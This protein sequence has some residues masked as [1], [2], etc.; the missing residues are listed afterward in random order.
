MAHAASNSITAH[1]TAGRAQFLHNQKATTA[2]IQRKPE[3]SEPAAGN[4]SNATTGGAQQ[5][6][7][8]QA[9]AYSLLAPSWQNSAG[10]SKQHEKMEREVRQEDYTRQPLISRLQPSLTRA[11]QH[12]QG[13]AAQLA[14]CASLPGSLLA[15]QQQDHDFKQKYHTPALTLHQRRKHR[16]HQVACWLA[17]LTW[18][19]AWLLQVARAAASCAPLLISGEQG[20]DLLGLA[21]AVHALGAKQQV[22]EQPKAC[23]GHQAA[24]EWALL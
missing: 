6:E 11:Q 1:T 4:A 5:Q 15:D 9:Q 12:P 13:Q 24:G 18:L 3:T 16:M 21:A 22:S 10:V 7:Q 19:G 8:Q 20:L 23:T 14:A 2:P 17:M